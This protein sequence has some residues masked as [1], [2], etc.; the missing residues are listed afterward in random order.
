MA[1]DEAAGNALA[2]LLDVVEA[3]ACYRE[4]QQKMRANPRLSAAHRRR[5]QQYL[6]EK[7]AVL[8]RT[9]TAGA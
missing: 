4:S 6:D 3:A 1:R 8:E 9:T 2:A 7:L 5:M